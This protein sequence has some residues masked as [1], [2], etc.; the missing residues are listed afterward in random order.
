MLNTIRWA[1]KIILNVLNVSLWD[2][3]W[4]PSS[5]EKN[6]CSIT[7]THQAYWWNGSTTDLYLNDTQSE[8]LPGYHSWSW[9][10]SSSTW[11]TLHLDLT[12]SK[13][14][15]AEIQH[16]CLLNMHHRMHNQTM[17]KS[18]VHIQTC[19]YT[20]HNLPVA[21]VYPGNPLQQFYTPLLQK[22]CST[23]QVWVLV[24]SG[25]NGPDKQSLDHGLIQGWILHSCLKMTI[26]ISV[27]AVFYY[28]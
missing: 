20:M 19:Q 6:P 14:M 11:Q 25:H 15:A 4:L 5:L 27:T 26:F 23:S 2:F 1:L 16:K 8:S 12:G 22:F 13:L 17:I 9:S 10:W 28:S 18:M 3:F 21:L 24:F 7:I